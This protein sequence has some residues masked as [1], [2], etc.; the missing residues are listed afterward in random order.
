[1]EAQAR[2]PLSRPEHP[3]GGVGALANQQRRSSGDLF[4]TEN[5]VFWNN[6]FYLSRNE[7]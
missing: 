5:S 7:F 3:E 2:E 6:D 1:M 4:F